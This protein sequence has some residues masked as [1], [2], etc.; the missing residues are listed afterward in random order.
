MCELYFVM[1]HSPFFCLPQSAEV[2]QQSQRVLVT[3]LAFPN[4]LSLHAVAPESRER[5]LQVPTS[6]AFTRRPSNQP[7]SPLQVQ[8]EAETTRKRLR[9]SML[10]AGELQSGSGQLEA[11]M[12]TI[13]GWPRIAYVIIRPHPHNEAL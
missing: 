10:R 5:G 6:A 13:A 11:C 8:R 9:A 4:L 3:L 2:T 1:S 7:S 12:G